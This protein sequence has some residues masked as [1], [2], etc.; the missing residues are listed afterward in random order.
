MR[1]AA[2]VNG[3][4]ECTPVGYMIPIDAIFNDTKKVTSAREV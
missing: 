4:P 2:P 1:K 3:G